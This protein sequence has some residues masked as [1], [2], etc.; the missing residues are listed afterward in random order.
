MRRGLVPLAVGMAALYL[1]LAVGAAG[2][3]FTPFEQP[4]TGHHHQKSHVPHSAFCAWACQANP[5]VSALVEAPHAVV[6]Q[7]VVLLILIR[8]TRAARLT[9]G[10]APPRAPPSF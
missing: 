9:V 5:T 7:L 10:A 4:D 3:L 1:V 6:F 8:T 2:C